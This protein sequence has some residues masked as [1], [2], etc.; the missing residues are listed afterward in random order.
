MEKEFSLAL[1]RRDNPL[2]HLIWLQCFAADIDQQASRSSSQTASE[3]LAGKQVAENKQRLPL[4][5]QGGKDSS[6]SSAKRES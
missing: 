3:S 6:S 5:G 4:F 1:C 2:A